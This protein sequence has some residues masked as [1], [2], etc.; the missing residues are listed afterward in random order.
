[1]TQIARDEDGQYTAYAWPGGYT[2]FHV[3]DDGGCLCAK[4]ANDPKNPVHEDEPNDGWRIIG[5]DINWEDADLL[6]DHCGEQIP[7]SCV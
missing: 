4:C 7:A 5:S 2:V 6:C 1:M 3:C